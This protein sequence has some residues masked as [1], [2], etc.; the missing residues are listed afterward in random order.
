M[1]KIGII[2]LIVLIGGFITSCEFTPSA[3]ERSE[4]ASKELANTAI[5]TI[6]VPVLSYFQERRTIAKWAKRFDQAGVITYV[7][8]ISYGHFI[9]YYVC[10][11]K[12]ASIRSY[13]TPE[14]QISNIRGNLWQVQAPDIDGTYGDNNLGIRFFTAEGTAVEW[15]GDGATYLFSDQPLPVDAPKLNIVIKK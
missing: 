11:G 4:Q 8:L 12:P 6:E 14:T 2:L 15:G 9:G 3:Q 5:N 1:K 13:L 10:D 7:Y